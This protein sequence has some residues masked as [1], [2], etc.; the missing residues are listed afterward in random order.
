MCAVDVE[1]GSYGVPTV[2]TD[3]VLGTRMSPL[4][5]ADAHDFI[6]S[7]VDGEEG[8]VFIEEPI[9][10][11]GGVRSTMVQAYMSGAVQAAFVQCGCDVYMVNV[12]KWKREV[13]GRGNSTK[14]QVREFMVAAGMPDDLSQDAYD[15]G[16]IAVYG[17]RL[18]LRR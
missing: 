2:I 15:A 9:V 14:E 17:A 12:S 6:V 5:L 4:V 10:G 13:I 1:D 11:R 8:L 16:A 18:V 7:T 3:T